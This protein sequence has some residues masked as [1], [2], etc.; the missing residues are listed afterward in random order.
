MTSNTPHPLTP[1]APTAPATPPAPRHGLPVPAPDA[2]LLAVPASAG[3]PDPHDVALVED[4]RLDV[5]LA[6][7]EPLADDAVAAAALALPSAVASAALDGSLFTAGDW[8]LQRMLLEERVPPDAAGDVIVQYARRCFLPE[9]G[10]GATS[11]GLT[12]S[13]VS[14]G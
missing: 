12:S 2:A 1:P 10:G 4:L 5:R 11:D 6:D 9:A 14:D 13:E 3:R 7:F 8:L